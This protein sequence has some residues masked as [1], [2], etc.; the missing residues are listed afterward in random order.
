MTVPDIER[1]EVTSADMLWD[2]LASHHSQ[3]ESVLLVTWKAAHRERYVSRNEVLDALVA[4]GW[5]DGRRY[6]LDDDRTM[7]LLSPR[8]QQA[9]AKSY[10]ERAERLEAEGKM[11]PPG[12]AA[13]ET[14][15][16]AGLWNASD[17]VDRL[18][19]PD[20]LVAALKSRDAYDWWAGAAPS[21][22]RNIL[23]W[24]GS[25]KK[26]DT[27]QKRITTVTEHAARAEKVP[28]Y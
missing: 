11:Q 2:W 23:R 24:I 13:I 18:D 9:W 6:K 15:K 26:P 19:E 4:Y 1:V 20:D 25:A 10:K 7:Q 21:Y 14:S 17:A 28:N 3:A 16:S 8:K 5:I 12:R 27:R 22:R